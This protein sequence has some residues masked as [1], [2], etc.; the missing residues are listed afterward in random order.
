MTL[1]ARDSVQDTICRFFVKIGNAGVFVDFGALLRRNQRVWSIGPIGK[2]LRMN[3][4][5]RMFG[6]EAPAGGFTRGLGK[7]CMISH[8]GR[9]VVLAIVEMYVINRSITRNTYPIEPQF[10]CAGD[11]WAVLLRCCALPCSL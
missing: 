9:M 11:H 5:G 7:S 8:E 6:T 3:S 1:M 4:T 10:Y 2:S